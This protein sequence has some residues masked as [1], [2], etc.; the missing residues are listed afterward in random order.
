MAP[1]DQELLERLQKLEDRIARLEENA[2]EASVGDFVFVEE[3]TPL[4]S[5]TTPPRARE[6]Q[7]KP[8]PVTQ[9]L[10]WA[11]VLAL[12]LAAAYVI[13]LG[14]DLGWLTPARQVMLAFTGGAALV[15]TG[16]ILRRADREYAS[17]LP[18][19]GIVILFLTVYGAH[20]YY[21]LIDFPI[22]TGAITLL[23]L[24][25]L[26]LCRY[27]AS[28]LYA[29]FAIVGSYTAP[30]LLSGLRAEVSDLSIYYTAW[31]LMYCAIGIWMRQRRIYLVAAY[32]ALL[33]FDLIW[34]QQWHHAAHPQWQAALIFQAA[35]FL[36]FAIGTAFYT[37]QHEEKLNRDTALAH[38]PPLLLFYALEYGLLDRYLHHYAPWIALASLLSLLAIYAIAR[39]AFR[40]SLEG[41]QLILSCYAAIVL[42]HAGYLELLPDHLAP[43]SG[44]IIGIIVAAWLIIKGKPNTTSWP[45]LGMLVL[46]FIINALRAMLN[47]D[48]GTVFAGKYLAVAY[49]AELYA[50][51][52]LTRNTDL[53]SQFRGALLYIGHLAAMAAPVHIFDNRLPV[54]FVWAL[55]AVVALLLA[56]RIRDRLLAQ[57]SLFVFAVSGAKV[58]LYDLDHAAPLIRIGCLVILGI[59][60]YI[61]GWLYR[62]VSEIES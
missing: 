58:L 14:I 11:G 34:Y 15:V 7:G 52:F 60:F 50:A 9:I 61:G 17:L 44:L 10:G 41:G 19:G 26:W 4:P 2:A 47:Y 39:I 35:Q 37:L 28:E 33:G 3:N 43:L 21:R 51:Y 22:A 55:L 12:V 40:Y 59:S 31:S 49:A 1:I 53:S 5:L 45:L 56:L 57:S 36:I 8:V 23:C 16:L 13:K 30:L 20:L 54:S 62:R 46:V 18:A 42:F 38:L 6:F 25:S 27:F 29:Y 24:L 32:L 48:L